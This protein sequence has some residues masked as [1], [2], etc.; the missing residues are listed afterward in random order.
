MKIELKISSHQFKDLELEIIELT[1][2]LTGK[3]AMQLYDHLY[4]CLE[5]DQICQLINFKGVKKVDRVAINVLKELSGKGLKIG[6]FAVSNKI[7]WCLR[8]SSKLDNVPIY[9]EENE[10]TVV[11]LLALDMLAGVYR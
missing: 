3:W 8:R 7:T 2:L 10:D 6:L 4:Y 1:G 5:N 11:K 9:D